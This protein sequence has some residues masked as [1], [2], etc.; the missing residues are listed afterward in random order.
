MTILPEKKKFKK[1]KSM[2]DI[3]RPTFYLGGGRGKHFVLL[4]MCV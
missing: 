1:V 4:K 3:H 2:C